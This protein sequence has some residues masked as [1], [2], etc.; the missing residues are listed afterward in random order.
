MFD[1]PERVLLFLA[2]SP[3]A[4][5]VVRGSFGYVKQLLRSRALGLRRG[6]ARE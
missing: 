2:R 4:R 5:I 6:R 3:N 1:V